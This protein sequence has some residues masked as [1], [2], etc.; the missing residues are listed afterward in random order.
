MEGEEV[1]KADIV[2]IFMVLTVE[3]GRESINKEN[4]KYVIATYGECH[5]EKP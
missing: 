1:S 5:E 4:N 3:L 2:P